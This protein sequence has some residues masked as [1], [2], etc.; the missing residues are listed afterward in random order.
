MCITVFTPTY[1]RGDLLIRVYESLKAQT[2]KDFEWLIV[3]DG[4]TDNT[5][6]VVAKL[7]E[8]CDF[9][10]RYILKENGGKHTAYNLA[11]DVAQGDYFFTVDSDDWLPKESL[12]NI[13]KLIV[14]IEDLDDVAGI[15]A[16]KEL[17]NHQIL[18]EPF[19]SEMQCI[20]LRQ[21]ELIGQA[22]ERSLVFKTEIA[23]Q[24]KFPVIF[25]ERFVTESVVYDQFNKDY[26][27]LV[28]N[29]CLTTCEYQDEGLSS[30]PRRLMLRNP[31]GYFIYYR[32]RIGM[33]ASWSERIGYMLRYNMFRHLYKGID[34]ESYLGKYSFMCKLLRVFTPFTLGYY[35][36]L[37]R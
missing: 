32:N 25:G 18:D 24:F 33:A 29:C 36:K 37:A 35:R 30:N 27:F 14:D 9:S 21:L 15:I 4:S 1:N 34:I 28:S 6:E 26:K 5:R 11:L 31:G 2:F 17:P 3:D 20:Q 8:E 23:K 10:I 16:L 19:V 7:Q 22:G 12:L 13:S